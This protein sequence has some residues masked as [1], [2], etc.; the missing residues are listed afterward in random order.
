MKLDDKRYMEL[1]QAE[2]DILKHF[3]EA[4]NQMN[5]NRCCQT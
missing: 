3:I 5:V 1:K 2:L 4:C